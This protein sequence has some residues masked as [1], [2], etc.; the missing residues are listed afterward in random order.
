MNT[1]NAY[2]LRARSAGNVRRPSASTAPN[3]LAMKMADQQGR[4][5][6]ARMPVQG[7]RHLLADLRAN[8][9]LACCEES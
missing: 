4:G 8:A 5:S 7:G 2:A 3:G 9:R 6:C 1:R